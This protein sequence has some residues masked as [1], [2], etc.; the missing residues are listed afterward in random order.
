MYLIF[1]FDGT[2]VDSF[3]MVIE[4]FNLLAND[5]NFRKIPLEE[6]DE[7]RH[8]NS[9]D[10]IKYLKIPIYKIPSVL[11]RARKYL[12]EEMHKLTPFIGIPKTLHDLS[13]AGFS[14][15][16][17]TSNSEENVI[18]WLNYHKMKQYFNFIHIESSYFGKKRILKKVM[19]INR[20]EKAFYIGDETRDIEAAKQCSM[21]SIAVTWGFNS[22]KILSQYH[23][24][25]IARV[26][27]DILTI[28]LKHLENRL[29]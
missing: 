19:K 16:I 12:Q 24:H 27:E 22:E 18:A 4:K 21:S 25:Y 15:G 29:Y 14:L 5:F 10:L 23:P 3:R 6:I 26:P 20:I 11:H 1:D 17:V 2:L 8:L 7:L 9:R 13:V 28:G